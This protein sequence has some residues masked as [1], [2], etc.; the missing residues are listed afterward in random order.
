MATHSSVIARRIPEMGSHRVGH[1]Q[2]DLAVAASH[3]YRWRKLKLRE[4]NSPNITKYSD[5]EG[6]G[7]RSYSKNKGHTSTWISHRH[8]YVR[9]HVWQK[10]TQF[11]KAIILQ[12]K[13]GKKKEWLS[14]VQLFAISWTVDCQ[15]SLSMGFS[16]QEY[17]S[18]LPFPSPGDLPDPG[19]EPSSPALQAD[20]LLSEPPGKHTNQ[21]ERNF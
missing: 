12:L 1:D 8:T 5:L 21:K 10:L 7:L 4:N 13:I 17:W 19:I 20:S 3:L 14:C 16:R 11:C 18:R 15:A 6:V 9:A 2:S